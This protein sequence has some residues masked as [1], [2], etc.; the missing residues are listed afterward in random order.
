MIE[1]RDVV[2]SHSAQVHCVAKGHKGL[3][4]STPGNERTDSL[5]TAERTRWSRRSYKNCLGHPQ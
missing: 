4:N 5:Y 3:R 1:A 2:L